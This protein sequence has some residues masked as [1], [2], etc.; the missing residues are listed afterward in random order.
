MIVGALI[1]YRNW[2]TV[3]GIFVGGY[4]R[5]MIPLGGMPSLCRNFRR[6]VRLKMA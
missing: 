3:I 6:T 2:W 1:G 4:A 5:V